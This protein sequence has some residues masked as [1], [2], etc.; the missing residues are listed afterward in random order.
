M[1][2]YKG[3]EIRKHEAR[4]RW[5]VQVFGAYNGPTFTTMTATLAFIDRMIEDRAIAH[6]EAAGINTA[7]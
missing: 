4:S 1:K 2:T 6:T 5:T 3:I 7:R